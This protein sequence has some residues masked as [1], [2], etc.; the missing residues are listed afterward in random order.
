MS[1]VTAPPPG[2]RRVLG[3]PAA[4]VRQVTRSAAT[5]P[6]RLSVIAIGLVLLTVLTGLVAAISM[7]QKST[8]ID[9]LVDHRE[10]LAA[11]AQQLYRS[12]SDA[13][14]TA[15]SAFLAEIGRAHV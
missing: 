7:Q 15:A 5:T 14:A 10:P 13:D 2:T 9:N 8:T 11:A 6:G 12:L 4:A 3:S 1:T